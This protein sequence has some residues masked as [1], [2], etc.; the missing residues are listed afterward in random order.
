MTTWAI[1]ARFLPSPPYCAMPKTDLAR[2]DLVVMRIIPILRGPTFLTLGH[3]H[4][5]LLPL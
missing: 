2:R 5:R 4:M 1:K 3:F